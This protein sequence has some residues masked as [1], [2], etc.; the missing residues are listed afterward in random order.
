MSRHRD[1]GA[2][3]RFGRA[4]EPR[5]ATAEGTNGPF[6][7]AVDAAD[8]SQAEPVQRSRSWAITS[9]FLY[10]GFCYRII[11]RPIAHEA[12]VALTA[13]EDE[14]L[15]YLEQGLSNKQIAARLGVSASTVGVL[16]HRAASR[17]RVKT[18]KD[19]V[20]AYEQLVTARRA[21]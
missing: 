14:V 6:P 5:S 7:G 19:L 8:K 2:P 17:F 16:I 18:R 21:R 1:F 3:A 10:E 11:R 13:R 20:T 12:D 9:E 4:L 15:S